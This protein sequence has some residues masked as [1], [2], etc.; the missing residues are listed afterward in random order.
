MNLAESTA[1]WILVVRIICVT[2]AAVLPFV[3]PVLFYIYF[4]G[5]IIPCLNHPICRALIIVLMF[6]ECIGLFLLFR[7][8]DWKSWWL[9]SIIFAQPVLNFLTFGPYILTFLQV[10]VPFTDMPAVPYGTTPSPRA[11]ELGNAILL[12]VEP[13]KNNSPFQL[14]LLSFMLFI[15]GVIISYPG[16][17]LQ[18]FALGKKRTS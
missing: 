14:H 7:A 3:G 15:V 10:V 1:K 18:L 13:Y 8:K 16:I 11:A 9:A 17:W 5:L 4:P 2:I 12:L 6:W